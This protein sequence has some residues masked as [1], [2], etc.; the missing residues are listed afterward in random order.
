MNGPR[1][2]RIMK[3]TQ[4]NCPACMHE[5]RLAN[6]HNK[7]LTVKTRRPLQHTCGKTKHKALNDIID[8]RLKMFV[9][10][11]EHFDLEQC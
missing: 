2:R 6:A 7:M 4:R 3:T 5:N 1:K 11:P 8:V 9:D 10:D